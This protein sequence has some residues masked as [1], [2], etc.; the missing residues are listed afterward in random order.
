MGSVPNRSP[1]SN[2]QRRPSGLYASFA[3]VELIAVVEDRNVPSFDVDHEHPG[4]ELLPSL[5]ALP[6]HHASLED[7]IAQY[8]ANLPRCEYRHRLASAVV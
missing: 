4:I 1:E 3:I 7:C 5:S 2:D 6:N 8:L